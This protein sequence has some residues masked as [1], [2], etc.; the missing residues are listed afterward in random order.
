MDNNEYQ[1]EFSEGDVVEFS[2]PVGGIYDSKGIVRGVASM[3]TPGYPAKYIVQ[4]TECSQIPNETY[5]FSSIAIWG[6]L[7]TKV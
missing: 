4:V 7:L 5:P 3:P 6:S 2:D 1:Y